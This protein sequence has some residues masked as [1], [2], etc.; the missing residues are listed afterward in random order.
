MQD[1]R[2]MCI[3]ID[4]TLLD[5]RHQLPPEN[6]AAVCWAAGHGAAVCLMTARPP[7]ATLPIQ[8]ELG[9]EL[10]KRKISLDAEIKAF[11]TYN[12]EIKLYAGVSAKVYVVV[13]EQ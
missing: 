3:D 5:A 8:K 1:I 4:G 7:G 13:S 10:D 6:R 2:L 9:V 11:G 12:A